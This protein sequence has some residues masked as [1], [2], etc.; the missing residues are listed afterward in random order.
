LILLTPNNADYY[1]YRSFAYVKINNYNAALADNTISLQLN[2]NNAVAYLNRSYI[3]RN[4]GKF[5][6]ALNDA[7]KAQTMGYP[8]DTNYIKELSR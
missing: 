4:L 1:F 2:P 5:D 8:V 6:N 7:M 3:Y